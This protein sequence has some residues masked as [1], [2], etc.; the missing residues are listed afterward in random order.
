VL[1]EIFTHFRHPLSNTASLNNLRN[2]INI[3]NQ[4]SGIIYGIF[5]VSSRLSVVAVL[6]L[7]K[8]FVIFSS[9]IMVVKCQSLIVQEA[10]QYARHCT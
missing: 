3:A 8:Y 4:K 1:G 10:D 9:L 5:I 2:Q 7:N 6:F